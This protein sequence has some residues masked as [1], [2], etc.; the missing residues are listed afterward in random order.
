MKLPIAVA[1]AFVERHFS[2]QVPQF[3]AKPEL[4]QFVELVRQGAQIAAAKEYQR[5][6]GASL[7][8]C[9]LATEVVRAADRG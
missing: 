7:N 1:V 8:E 2:E 6:T 9:Q 3:I 5:V 4:Q